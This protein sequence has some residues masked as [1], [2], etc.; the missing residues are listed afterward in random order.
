MSSDLVKDSKITLDRS[1]LDEVKSEF[2]I[3]NNSAQEECPI[4]YEPIPFENRLEG[5]CTN[6]HKALRC[7]SSLR[8]CFTDTFSCRWCGAHYHL[9]S[10]KIRDF[11]SLN[12]YFNF[13]LVLTAG[14]NCCILCGGPLAQ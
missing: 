11:W 13:L 1:L 14:L 2:E 8:T 9:E 10:G 5:K 6:G 12:Y 4:C 7:R 3:G